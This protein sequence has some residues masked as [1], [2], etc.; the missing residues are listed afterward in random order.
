MG[1]PVFLRNAKAIVEDANGD[2]RRVK[3]MGKG[4]ITD[5]M[6]SFGVKIKRQNLGYFTIGEPTKG[7]I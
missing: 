6:K 1:R 3:N 4:S 7:A 5:D 2:R